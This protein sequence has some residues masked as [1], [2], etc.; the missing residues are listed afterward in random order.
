[1]CKRDAVYI[2]GIVVLRL[3]VVS[4]IRGNAT[5][6]QRPLL[7]HHTGVVGIVVWENG[8][9]GLVCILSIV[10][11]GRPHL[12]CEY[13]PYKG[14]EYVGLLLFIRQNLVFL[15]SLLVHITQLSPE[16]KLLYVTAFF[17]PVY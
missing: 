3:L 1:F 11:P 7:A 16:I 10:N 14:V 5:I 6:K 15:C 2:P 8:V 9:V 17:R 12:F 4:K 13:I